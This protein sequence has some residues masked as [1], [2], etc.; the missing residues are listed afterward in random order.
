ML[1]QPGVL[2]GTFEMLTNSS[3]QFAIVRVITE[4]QN[5]VQEQ[6]Q[7]ILQLQSQQQQ[8]AQASGGSEK[9]DQEMTRWRSIDAVPKFTG[10]V[11][12]FKDFEFKL[13]QF[14]RPVLGFEKVLDWIKDSEKEPDIEMLRNYKAET[15]YE[16][17]YLNEQMYGILSHVIEGD[18]LET[19][20]NLSDE[21][22][23]R[24]IWSWYRLTREAAGKTGA[25]LK[26]LSD[27]AHRPKKIIDYKDAR[28]QLTAWD[29]TLKQLK[30]VEGQELSDLTKITT[31]ANM[32][33]EDLSQDIDKDESLT[34]FEEIWK[35]V[36][37]QVEVR[38]HWGK[39]NKKDPN[40]MDVDAMEKENEEQEKDL[41]CQPCD[42]LDTL[43]EVAETSSRAIVPTA[44]C[45]VA[46]GL[47]VAR[48][49]DMEKTGGKGMEGQGKDCKGQE[50]SKV[51]GW[52]LSPKGGW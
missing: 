41:E 6:H 23:T 14:V 30:K 13:H 51:K 15:H 2:P 47:I 46:R 31:L 32:V 28:V 27:K 3:D 4:L 16:L 26:R 49:A 24:G 50:A 12:H 52:Q 45:G 18:A 34:T 39:K 1:A 36:I 20:M 8:T 21:H 38:K 10:D 40:A 22:S 48:M 17:E 11:K 7:L 33:P 42:E 43:K 25:R 29:T 5:T 44:T 9:K 37:K 35:Y 19:L